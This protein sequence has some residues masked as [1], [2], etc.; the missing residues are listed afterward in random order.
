M[1]GHKLYPKCDIRELMTRTESSSEIS[2]GLK[3]M[4]R[5]SFREDFI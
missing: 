4:T 3:Q 5:L 2:N 1:C